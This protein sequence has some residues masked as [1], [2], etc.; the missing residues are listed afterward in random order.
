MKYRLP[1][2]Y[3]N[4]QA[5]IFLFPYREDIWRKKAKPIQQLIVD[6]ANI[7][8]KYEHVILGV[9]P[10]LKDYLLNNFKL[11]PKV[12]LFEVKY[13]D[14]WP[15]DSISSIVLSKKDA[16]MSSIKFNAYGDGLYF[17][18]DDDANL[19]KEFAKHLGLN[20]KEFP[21]TLEGGNMLPDGNGTLFAVKDSI[22]NPNRNPNMKF[23][24]VEKL[25]KKATCSNKIVWVNHGLLEDETGGHIDN[26]L[27]FAD[28]NTLLMS[29]TDDKDD[30]QYDLVREVYEAIKKAKS[31]KTHKKYKIVKVPLPPVHIR[32]KEESDDIIEK[33]KSFGRTEGNHIVETYINIVLAN[34][35]VIVPQYGIPDKDAEALEIMKQVF[36]NRDIYPLNGRE[37]SLGGGGFHCLSK[38]ISK[39]GE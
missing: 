5:T 38:H 34:G 12:E 22:F 35:V 25:L 36:P 8:V 2:E 9:L 6:M 33:D 32:T 20:I 26:L 14:A 18:W 7:V 23:K 24:D 16:Y 21:I 10:E 13:N 3:E 11:D 15:R 39:I 1:G 4:Q 37:A 17:P 31:Q 19:D 27:A 28:E 30:Y 29:W